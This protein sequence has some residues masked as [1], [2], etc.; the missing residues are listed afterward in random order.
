MSDPTRPLDRPRPAG[1]SLSVPRPPGALRRFWRRHPWWVDSLVAV[2]Y[3]ALG[4]L[5]Y[6]LTVVTAGEPRPTGVLIAL[7][8][9][10]ALGTAALM[11]RRRQPRLTFAGMSVV[12]VIAVVADGGLD[13]LGV[14]LALYALA[15]YRSASSAWLGFAVSSVLGA[16][17]AIPS[18]LITRF[19]LAS[20]EFPQVLIGLFVLTILVATLAGGN[21]GARRRYEQALLDRAEQLE[22]ERD[23]QAQLATAAERARITREMHDVVAHS[24]SI[25]VSL[26]DG[27]GALADRDPE[28]ARSAIREIGDVGRRSLTEMRRLLGVM[29][30]GPQA[31]LDAA[32]LQPQP[33]VGDLPE[34]IATLRTAGLPV[35]VESHGDPPAA[36]GVQAAIYRITQEALTNALRYAQTPTRVL[37]RFDY[38]DDGTEITVVDDGRGPRDPA[39][40]SDGRGLIGMRERAQLYG[41]TMDAGPLPAGGWRVHV[42]LPEARDDE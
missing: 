19:D 30:N 7:M 18:A 13:S 9:G 31:S 33:Q 15:V 1:G 8:A 23:Q 27:A 16:A 28:R 24:L 39:P 12:N 22:R 2:A 14:S 42:T 25:M 21:V 32:P 37:V 20:V 5:G 41:G 3:L 40:H 10:L 35:A 17:L 26:S 4:L 34:L 36:S 11:A 29:G 6:V 38:R